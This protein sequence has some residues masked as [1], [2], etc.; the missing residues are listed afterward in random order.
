MASLESQHA[1][2]LL[3]KIFPAM[4]SYLLAFFIGIGLFTIAEAQP[5]SKAV[6]IY[7][8]AKQMQDQGMYLEAVAAYKKAILADKSY[9]SSHLALASLYLLISQNDSAVRVLKAAVK[10]KPA[11]TSAHELLGMVHRDYIKNSAEAIL[12]YSNAVKYDSTNKAT[13]YAL[14]WCSNDLKK[15]SEAVPYAIKALDIDN[16]YRPAYN[17]L[18]HAYRRLGTFEEAIATFKKRIAISVTDQPLYYSGLCYIELK[19]K[20]DAMRMYEELVKIQ[21]KSAAALKKR[22]D[23]MQ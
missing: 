13:W 12:H 1:F 20:E 6:P 10:N 15:Y 18:A 7:K 9:D 3:F 16:S 5:V 14:A 22:I 4:R 23:A 11:F 19:N 17:E 8:K 2:T 21:A